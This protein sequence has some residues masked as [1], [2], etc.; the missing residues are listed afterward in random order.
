M[1]TDGVTPTATP[2]HAAVLDDSRFVVPSPPQRL[3]E[4]PR[5]TALLDRAGEVPLTLVSAPAGSGK[6]TLVADWAARRSATQDTLWITVER[7]A[8]D[9]HDLWADVE[10][11]LRRDEV[12]LGRLSQPLTLVLDGCEVLSPAVLGQLELVLRRGGPRL[13]VVLLTR[14]DPVPPVNGRRRGGALLEVRSADL[15]FT[16]EETR[17]LVALA[18][19]ELSAGAAH[20]LTARTRGWAAGVRF[21]TTVLEGCEEPDAVVRHLTAASWLTHLLEEEGARR[22]VP[23]APGGTRVVTLRPRI[24]APRSDPAPPAP[25]IEQLTARELEVLECLSE[26]LSTDEIATTMFVSVNTVRTHVRSILRKLSVS[27]RNEAVRRGRALGL[28]GA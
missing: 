25:I 4:R 28:V 22:Y 26:L 16:E 11:C 5:L 24:P 7:S 8:S 12:T 13:H 21:A 10:E 3:L 19:A 23:V 27:R 17:R 1:P 2:E 18:G 6:T 9:H 15:A 14:V 20:A